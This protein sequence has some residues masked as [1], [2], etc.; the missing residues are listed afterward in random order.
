MGLGRVIVPFDGAGASTRKQYLA[1]EGAGAGAPRPP[2]P[3]QPRH[4]LQA[5]VNVEKGHT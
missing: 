2:P 3:T 4:S 1:Y 5:V